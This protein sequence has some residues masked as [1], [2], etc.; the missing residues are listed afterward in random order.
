MHHPFEVI[1]TTGTSLPGRWPV[2]RASP[3]SADGILGGKLVRQRC[4]LLTLTVALLLNFTCSLATAQVTFKPFVDYCFINSMS[5]DGSVAVGAYDNGTINDAFRWTAAG[6]VELIG[7]PKMLGDTYISRDGKT[8]VSTVPDSAGNQNA[9]IWLGGRQWKLLI[10]FSGAVPNPETHTLSYASGVSG[11]GTIIVGGVYVSPTKVVAFRWDSTNGMANLGTFDEGS[12]SDSVA[13]AVSA[14]GNN[15]IGWD[16]KEGFRPPGPG[17]IAMNGRR[18]AIWWD[19]KERMLHAFGWAGEAWATN[20]VGSIIVGQFHPL[21]TNNLKLQGGTTYRWTAWDGHF[22]DLGTAPAPIGGAQQAQISQ[23]YAV[24]DDGS[25]VGGDSG[26]VNSKGAMIWT[27]ETG[28]MFVTNYLTLKGVTDH[29]SW[30][31][32]TKTV[33][34]SPDGRVMVGYGTVRGNGPGTPDVPKTWIVTLR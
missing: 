7:V 23:P 4:G 3:R 29:L 2:F 19:G 30:L 11:D 8:I 18:G 31:T 10:P 34:I 12:N 27:Y 16:Y 26:P 6:G 5:A 15:V 9:A 24:S 25:V 1:T 33:Y 13:Y 20:D 17:G 21:N 14:D 28:M 32:L 22:E